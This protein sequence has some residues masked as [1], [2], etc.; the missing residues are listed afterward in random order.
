MSK[1]DIQKAY[2]NVDWLLL[3]QVME[4]LDIPTNFSNWIMECVSTVNYAIVVITV[5]EPGI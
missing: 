3:K 5:A 4:G 2:D 1:V